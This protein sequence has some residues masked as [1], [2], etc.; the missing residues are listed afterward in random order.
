MC[1]GGSED[2]NEEDEAEEGQEYARRFRLEASRYAVEELEIL[3][4]FVNASCDWVQELVNIVF[5]AH[6]PN[7]RII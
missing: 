6:N 2:S 3:E 1:E 4:V 5:F 7:I